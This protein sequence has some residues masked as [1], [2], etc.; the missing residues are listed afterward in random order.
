MFYSVRMIVLFSLVLAACPAPEGPQPNNEPNNEP[1]N[2]PEPE[3][4]RL[5]FEELVLP[6]MP[7]AMT[8]IV[9]VPGTDTFLLLRK[10]GEVHHYRVEGDEVTLLGQTTVPG[11]DASSDCGLISGTFAPDGQTLYLGYCTALGVNTVTRHRFDAADLDAV[12]SGGVEVVTV[13]NP[14]AEKFWHNVGSLRVDDE[15]VLWALFGE[16][17]HAPAAQD[18]SQAAGSVVRVVPNLDGPGHTPAPGNPYLD[19]PAHDPIIYASGLR[20]PW[21]GNLDAQGRF[22]IGDVGGMDFEELNVL[23]A[24]GQN[25]GWPDHE[26]LCTQD[27]DAVVDPVIHWGR[28][29][30]HPFVFD[31][32]E[33]S[34]TNRRAIWVG[35]EYQDNPQ[36]PYEGRLTGRTLYGDFCTGWVRA[37]SLDASGE[38][39]DDAHVGHLE[40]VVSWAQAPDGHAYVVTY[41]NC[42]TFPY[43]PGKLY[44]AVLQK[45]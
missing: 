43:K 3:A 37:A 8:E 34:P 39:E 28:S 24:P 44:R 10:A 36:D 31:D 26:G 18:L 25:F 4:A 11:V 27:C 5:V 14:D 40:G 33:T 32:P 12:A 42:M 23:S 30:E 1:N 45:P 2:V 20:S 21:K 19:T 6:D 22:W 9:W 35:I 17:A 29:T 38:L 7:E 41:G 13:T 16:N 15:G